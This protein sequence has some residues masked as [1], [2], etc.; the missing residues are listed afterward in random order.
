MKKK[1]TFVAMLLVL[2]SLAFLPYKTTLVPEW[3]I[4]VED[5]NGK[6]YVN[7]LV[8]QTCENYTLNVSP[9]VESNDVARY[10]DS[11]GYVTFP[12]RN[13][14]LSLTSRI[15]RSI[16]SYLKLIAHGSVGID[17]NIHA[18]G[19]TGYKEIRYEYEK[20]LPQKLVLPSEPSKSKE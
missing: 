20:T 19:P 8:G 11:E 10:T 17:V 7:K 14:I 3:T 4:R 9:C 6:P 12:E 18:S 16:F 1:I 2:S 5:E 13:I 15:F